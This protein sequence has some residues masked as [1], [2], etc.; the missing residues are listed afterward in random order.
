[1]RAAKETLL[2]QKPKSFCP[3]LQGA[4]NCLCVFSFLKI[5]KFQ[6][7]LKVSLTTLTAIKTAW[8]LNSPVRDTHLRTKIALP[9]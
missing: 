6:G 4:E 2:L 3:K 9:I 8:R 7:G 1:M 5:I